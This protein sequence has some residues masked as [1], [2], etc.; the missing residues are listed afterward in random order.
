M[1]NSPSDAKNGSKSSTPGGQQHSVLAD[2]QAQAQL[3]QVP[4]RPVQAQPQPPARPSLADASPAPPGVGVSGILST[5]AARR[6]SANA[7]L[8]QAFNELDGLREH[9]RQ[10]VA[11][12]EKYVATVNKQQAAQAAEAKVQAQAGGANG[13]SPDGVDDASALASLL[14]TLGVAEPVTKQQAGAAWHAALC[15]EV[16]SSVL[17]R[18]LPSP[19]SVITLPDLY[20]L[21]NRARGTELIS[22][23]DLRKAMALCG[24][25]AGSGASAAYRLKEF[26]NGVIVMTRASYTD[27]AMCNTV[28]QLL[29]ERATAVDPP[30]SPGNRIVFSL[31][32]ITALHAATALS[33]SLQVAR[34]QLIICERRALLCRDVTVEETRYYANEFSCATIR[35]L[36]STSIR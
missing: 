18:A 12:A 15:R 32:Y 4:Q 3:K 20:C 26:D 36:Y 9:A 13:N 10:V 11:I 22:P 27:D 33:C 1:G 23:G 25:G 2:A 30:P 14:S 16:S 7:T 35:K 31:A 19:T 24:G 34:Q 28:M 8:Q 5:H 17:P 29:S 6:D 21:V